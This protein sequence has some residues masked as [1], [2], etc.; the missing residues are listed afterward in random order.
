MIRSILLQPCKPQGEL[1]ARFTSTSVSEISREGTG[2]HHFHKHISKLQ[3]LGAQHPLGEGIQE[4]IRTKKL[5][6]LRI[7]HFS[8]KTERKQT[9]TAAK[10]TKRH[11]TWS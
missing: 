10:V 1:R 5:P 11:Q 2:A 6:S 8:Y 4:D 3:G 7:L 9:P